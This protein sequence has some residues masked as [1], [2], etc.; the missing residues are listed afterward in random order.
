MNARFTYDAYSTHQPVLYEAVLRT[1]GAVMEFGCGHGSTIMLHKLCAKHGRKLVTVESNEEWM[2]K[3]I[4]YRTSNHEFIQ[5]SN[6]EAALQDIRHLAMQYDVVFIDQAPWEARYSTIQAIK[7][8]TKYIVLHDCNYFPEHGIFGK[9]VHGLNGANSRGSRTYGDV[10]K[11]WNEYFPLEPWPHPHTGPPT[12][13]ASNF[14]SCD[15]DIDFK[16]YASLEVMC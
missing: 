4:E 12:L 9:N 10:F 8:S 3:F 1:H 11:Y 5:V 6:W 13:L 15:W 14:K 16:N 2:D 7:D